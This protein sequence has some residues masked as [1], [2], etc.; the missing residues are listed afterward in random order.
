MLMM[1]MTSAGATSQP[2]QSICSVKVFYF[3]FRLFVVFFFQI[4]DIEHTPLQTDTYKYIYI[5]I[6][7]YFL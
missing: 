5:H 4:L 3:P 1:M 6:Y 7:L 2:L